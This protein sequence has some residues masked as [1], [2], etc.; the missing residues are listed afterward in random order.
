MAEENKKFSEFE[1][2]NSNEISTVD[3]EAKGKS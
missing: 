3:F 1:R 2:F